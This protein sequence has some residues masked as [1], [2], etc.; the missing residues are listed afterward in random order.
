MTVPSNSKVTIF[1]YVR[2]ETDTQKHFAVPD[3]L[4]YAAYHAAVMS[5]YAEQNGY[6]Y[7]FITPDTPEGRPENLEPADVRWGKVKLL[8]DALGK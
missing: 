7:R 8:I 4:S 6:H 1:T 3:I 2:A 5:A